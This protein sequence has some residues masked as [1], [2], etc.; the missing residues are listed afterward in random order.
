MME[1]NAPRELKAFMNE[2]MTKENMNATFRNEYLLGFMNLE[3]L[4]G[5]GGLIIPIKDAASFEKMVTPLL[6]KMPGSKKLEK[7]GKGEAFT[8]HSNR[9][10]AIGWNDK[11]ALIISG[12]GYAEQ[13]LI[14]LTKMEASEN[15]NATPYFKDFFNNGKDMGVHLTSTPLST[16]AKS[17]LSSSAGININVENNNLEYHTNFEDDHVY[18]QLQL[19]LN[20][21]LKSLIGYKSWMSTRY[22]AKLLDV[23][24]GD[25]AGVMKMSI[26]FNAL[27]KHIESLQENTIIPEM[28]RNQLTMSMEMANNQMKSAT[29]MDVQEAL[30]IFDGSMMIG[31]KEGKV[32]KDSIRNYYDEDK[33]YT[34]FETKIPYTYAAISIKDMPKFEKLMGLAMMMERPQNTKGKNYF[35][36][37][38]EAFVLVKDNVLY[39][40]NDEST[41]DE[42]Y[43][44]GK[45]AANLSGFEH[46]SKLDNS[47]F[48]YMSPKASKLYGDL[49]SSMNPYASMYGGDFG[50]KDSYELMGEYFG[51]SFVTMNP[52]D[53]ME[54][55]TYTKGEGNSLK[56]MVMYANAMVEQMMTMFAQFR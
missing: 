39:M 42:L 12:S 53:G 47:M 40:T 52:S 45:L 55:F 44:N 16:M 19:K 41:A 21:D 51:E 14:D 20:D 29:E 1:E 34:V 17:F 10:L 27:Y 18:T 5:S 6:E 30:G 54:T 38:D 43:K 50:M 22:D 9:N 13:E 31:L 8:V 49:M 35:Q 37:S 3:R 26:D 46:K 48:F 25:V 11:T 15:I 24:P 4:S 33:D 7:V 36:M 23:I 56:R 32:V 28:M 2:S